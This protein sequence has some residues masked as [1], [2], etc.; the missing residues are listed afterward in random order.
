M[1]DV[2]GK[3]AVDLRLGYIAHYS[4]ING[5]LTLQMQVNSVKMYL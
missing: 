3:F 4:H 5:H 1:R 2:G